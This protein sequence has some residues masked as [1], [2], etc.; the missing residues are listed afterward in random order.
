MNALLEKIHA[1]GQDSLSEAEKA[2]LLALRDRL[3]RR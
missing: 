1:S 2:E 3:R